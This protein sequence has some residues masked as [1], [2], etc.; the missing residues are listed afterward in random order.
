VRRLGAWGFSAGTVTLN[1]NSVFGEQL[2]SQ[3]AAGNFTWGT[4]LLL[5]PRDHLVVTVTGLTGTVTLQGQA[6]EI[7]TLWL[8]DYLL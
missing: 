6:F 4:S 7:G 1:L 3:T 2:A 5:A 8:P